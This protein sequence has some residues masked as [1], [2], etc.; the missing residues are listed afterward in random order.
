M[1]LDSKMA[2][3]YRKIDWNF[4]RFKD[5]KHDFVN[6]TFSESFETLKKK[7]ETNISSKT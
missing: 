3:F 5:G 7:K 4:W 2:H 6:Y 1:K